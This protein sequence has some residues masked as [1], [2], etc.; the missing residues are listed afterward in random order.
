MSIEVD[1]EI[2]YIFEPLTK[3]ARYKV[4]WG[5][6]GSAKSHTMATLA[7]LEAAN[8]CQRY[9][10]CREYQT[11]IKNSVKFLLDIKIQKLGL[12]DYFKSTNTEI[13][14]KETGA[15]FVFFGLQ[16]DPG[17]IASLEGVTRCWIEEANR[18]SQSSW[19][20]LIPTI[21]QPD[22]EIWACFNPKLKTDPAYQMFVENPRPNATVIKAN[23]YDNPWFPDVLK[24]E[25]E[26][27][28]QRDDG[29]YRHIWLGEPVK[30]SE[31]LVF[32]GKWRT[33]DTIEPG[34]NEIIRFGADFG[35]SNDPSTLLRM[36]VNEPKREIYVDYEAY[37]VGVEIEDMDQFYAAIPGSKKWKITADSARPET[38]SHLRNKKYNIVAAKKG[39][40]SVNEGIEFLKSYTIV[41]HP[42][43]VHTID[44]LGLFS[45][46]VDK[47]TE[48]VFPILEDK[49]NQCIDAMRYALEQLM[50]NRPQRINIG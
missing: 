7:I 29:K 33:D 35:F 24:Q 50:F 2:P 23:Y 26:Y 43:C 3:P 11:T 31:A 4:A 9:L 1:V 40:G 28:R 15:T 25:M 49:N 8:S 45:Y 42:R 34:E 10:C 38:I 30:N 12:T 47:I 5:G 19:D 17:K 46:K 32:N 6:R 14:N 20:F 22:S 48:E 16:T 18:V 13:I 41:V 36:W 27:D 37:G 39:K 21:R 44:E